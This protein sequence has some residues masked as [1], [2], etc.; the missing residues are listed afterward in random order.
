MITTL[1]AAI[2]LGNG[3]SLSCPVTGEA[4]SGKGGGT[5]VYA[6]VRY[7]VCCAGCFP[8][9]KADPA[10][11][12]GNP[13]LKGKTIGVSMYD[14]VATT[15]VDLKKSKAFSD[16][17]GVRFYFANAANK[18]TFDAAPEKFGKIPAKEALW[19]GVMNHTITGYDT[20]GAY[21]DQGDTR[22]YV[23]CPGCLGKFKENPQAAMAK[24]A[25]AVAAPKAQEIK[26]K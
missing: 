25:K 8:K 20:A 5:L 21:V 23:C 12:I 10:K 24:S 16:Y 13:D 11:A 2:A 1:I 4:L 26:A 14:P 6:G 19:C 22:Y 7:T 15:H 18:K 3:T 17:N 9:L